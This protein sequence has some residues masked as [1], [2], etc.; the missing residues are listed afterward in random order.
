MKSGVVVA[1]I[2]R[3]GEREGYAVISKRGVDVALDTAV[4][5]PELVIE[6]VSV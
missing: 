6:D 4:T 1:A 3:V 5:D 2:E